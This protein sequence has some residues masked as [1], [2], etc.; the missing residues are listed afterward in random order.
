MVFRILKSKGLKF[1]KNKKYI[2]K[3]G[4]YKGHALLNKS[5]NLLFI[6][7]KKTNQRIQLNYNSKN[8][9]KFLLS[10]YN[11]KFLL[12]DKKFLFLY[13][14]YFAS[15]NYDDPFEKVKRYE[16]GDSEYDNLYR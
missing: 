12:R 4:F 13:F 3:V 1:Y 2:L 5:Y 7:M 11:L 16:E 6:L 15:K 14:L 10:N 9:D 8:L